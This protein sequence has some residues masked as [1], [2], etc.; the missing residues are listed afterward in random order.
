MLFIAP[1]M[2]SSLR[3]IPLELEIWFRHMYGYACMCTQAIID[4]CMYVTCTQA[5]ID[6]CMYVTCTQAIIDRC[7]YV[8]YTQ[9]HYIDIVILPILVPPA[10]EI[11]YTREMAS[12]EMAPRNTHI[13]IYTYTT[14]TYIL[15]I[16]NTLY[17]REMASREMPPQA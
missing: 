15:H 13:H 10:N 5:I 2:I 9:I 4:R 14:Y 17:S 8:T 12:R 7:M 6:R 1:A 16:H 11:R 3:Y